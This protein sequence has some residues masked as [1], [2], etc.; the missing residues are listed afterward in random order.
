[1][2]LHMRRTLIVMADAPIPG[3]V[4]VRLCPPLEVEAATQLHHC[5]VLDA[6]EKASTVPDAQVIVCCRPAGSLHFFKEAGIGA[7]QYLLQR[8]R[9][10][11]ERAAYCIE[12]VWHPE[13]A[14]VVMGVNAPTLP[15]RCLELA[16][17]SLGSGSVDVVL[18][19]NGSGGCYLVGL[20]SPL[21]ELFRDVDWSAPNALNRCVEHLARR[22]LGWYLLPEWYQVDSP[23]GLAHLKSELLDRWVNGPAAGHTRAYMK[24]LARAGMI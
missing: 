9:S 11:G 22:G 12:Q 2:D 21:P 16:F 8:G 20:R 19:P 14:A 17:D 24:C 1:V 23:G 15:L 4:N 5:F 13:S 6:A 18:G 7:D 3:K 10:W